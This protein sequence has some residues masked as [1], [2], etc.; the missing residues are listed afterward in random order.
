LES[1]YEIYRCEEDFFPL[2]HPDDLE[3]Y[4]DNMSVV[5]DPASPRGLAHTFNYRIVR[6]N[7]EVRHVRELEYGAQVEDGVITR[8][9]GAIQD[10][11]E[12]K[13]R[14]QD[15]EKQN[16]LVQQFELIPEIGHYIWS[17]DAEKYIYVSPGLAGIYGISTNE[18]LQQ[19]TSYKDD[20]A[21]L[22]EDD[23]ERMAKIYEN[24]RI[25]KHADA[26]FRV[27]RPG[28]EIRW[29]REK[30][31]VIWDS[32]IREN[33]AIGVLQDVTEQKKAEQRLLEVN[34]SLET[35]LQNKSAEVVLRTNAQKELEQ[36]ESWYAMAATTA[37]LGHWHFDEVN[38]E[39]LNISDQYAEI[40]GY[41][42]DEFLKRFRTYENDL[43]LIHPDDVERVDEAYELKQD[44]VE[45]D[46]RILHADG[47]VRHVREISRYILD[48]SNNVT[49]SMGTLQDITELKEAQFESERANRAK[50][51]FLSRMSHELRTPLNAILGF[52]QLFEFDQGLGKQR[53]SNARAIN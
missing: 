21:L 4:I 48:S 18:I 44:V 13:E 24:R 12:L 6:P 15:L 53:Q 36:S 33:Q 51:E 26:E 1:L 19:A 3:H 29:I 43:A 47:E 41:S 30:S 14:Q 52:S 16:V 25:D 31:I 17:L 42:P 32:V 37:K 7:G 8:S 39:Y 49:E 20:I 40:F 5:L 2:V 38:D 50:S 11:T 34:D 45:I 10:I 28:G 9:F 27:R 22:H 46:Y 23:R 35:E